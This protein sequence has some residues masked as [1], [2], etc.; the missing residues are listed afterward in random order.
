M[1]QLLAQGFG[2][3]W[4]VSGGQLVSTCEPGW[5]AERIRCCARSTEAFR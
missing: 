4:R 1:T 3:F 5:F 2:T